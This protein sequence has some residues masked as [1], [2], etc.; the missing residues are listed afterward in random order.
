MPEQPE[1]TQSDSTTSQAPVPDTPGTP[2]ILH[3]EVTRLLRLIEHEQAAQAE[4]ADVQPS[5]P[6]EPIAA[7]ASR[8]SYHR[9]IFSTGL[10]VWYR[11]P[12]GEIPLTLPLWPG[13]VERYDQQK[14]T[15]LVKPAIVGYEHETEVVSLTQVVAWFHV[16]RSDGA[17]KEV[18]LHAPQF[19]QTGQADSRSNSQAVD[20]S[21]K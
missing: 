3:D 2:G 6:T 4:L 18:L 14:Q 11:L 20:E 17:V 16:H 5:V 9:L 15:V 13:K 10:Y 19:E 7:T 12:D 1:S 21:N 8:A